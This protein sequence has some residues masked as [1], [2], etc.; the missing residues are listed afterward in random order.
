MFHSRMVLSEEQDKKEQGP[1][2]LLAPP[3]PSGYT[4]GTIRGEGGGVNL[5]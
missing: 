5:G 1:A 3:P 2:P 4:C